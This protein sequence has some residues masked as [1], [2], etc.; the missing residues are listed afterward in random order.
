MNCL[1]VF[2]FIDSNSGLYSTTNLQF[3]DAN[4]IDP[5]SYSA[6]SLAS[7]S[8]LYNSWFVQSKPNQIFGLQ[9]KQNAFYTLLICKFIKTISLILIISTTLY[10]IY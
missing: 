8:L 9:G 1:H 7:A 6:A 10:W 4:V 3:S 2:S 5:S